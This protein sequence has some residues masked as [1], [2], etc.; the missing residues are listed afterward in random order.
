MLTAEYSA[1]DPQSAAALVHGF[2]AR[3][4][5]PLLVDPPLV[6][7]SA[8]PFGASLLLALGP[9]LLLAWLLLRNRPRAA[10]AR[11]EK[12]LVGTLGVPIVAA[13]PLAAPELARQLLAHWF[14]CGR[15]VLA[16]VSAEAL[17]G[18]AQVAAE[19]ARAC[20]RNGETTLLIDADFRAP[21][22]HRAFGV[23]NRRGLADFLDGGDTELAQCADNLE[24]L[25]AGRSREDPL[26]LLSRRRM[27]ALLAAAATR[28]RVVL[29]H[30]P[31]AALGPDLQL[32]AAFAGGALVVTRFA[33]QIPALERLRDLL[34]FCRARV[35][36][37]I[38][39]S[40]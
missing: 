10:A 4:K 21:A 5:E 33:T 12:N 27:Q 38:L 18:A 11:S 28:Y 22:L 15:P 13:R 24:L 25:V 17:D 23:G 39:S 37:T 40:T 35:V 2:I 14:G 36:G 31:A 7:R 9:A 6:V 3:H 19:L 26:E 30:T 32:P 29:V 20:A 16:V 8:P 1:D 34:A